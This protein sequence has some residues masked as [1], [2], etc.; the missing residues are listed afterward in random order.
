[1]RAMEATGN[2]EP[3]AALRE[4]VRLLGALLGE[5]IGEQEGETFF[6]LV[7]ATRT[8]S[9]AE[10][11]QGDAG[12]PDAPLQDLG[13]QDAG[14]L[15]Q[16]FSQYFMLVNLAERI[17]RI[18]RLRESGMSGGRPG[19]GTFERVLEKLRDDGLDAESVGRILAALRVMPVFTAHPTEA[20]RPALLR[21]EQRVARALLERLPGGAAPPAVERRR[22]ERIREEVTTAWQTE[23]HR[24]ERPT[25]ADER[26]HIL[27]YLTEVIY[28]VVP[29]FHQEL[30]EAFRDVF[31]AEPEL[32]GGV[33]RFGSWVGGDMDGNPHV[34]ADTLRA[35]L[36]RQ[37]QLV[38]G[39]YLR[40]A[41]DLGRS[42]TQATT[43]VGID[44]AILDRIRA[45]DA[46]LP[47]VERA[48]AA[49]LR[50]RPYGVFFGRVRDRLH[51]RLADAP[52][53]YPG[54]EALL[55]DL[56]LVERSIL[57]NRG[58][59]AG[60]ASVRAFMRRI[61]TFGFHLAAL[62]V[63][64]D[65]SVHRDV[66]AELIGRPDFPAMD[67]AER[68]RLLASGP[69][70]VP[71]P[72]GAEAERA[73]EVMRAL[74][75]ARDRFG[76]DALGVYVISMA[77]GPDDALA[78]LVLA[79]A[80]GLVD[81]QG[82][83]PLDI[84][85]LFETVA[86]LDAARRTL[87][88]LLAEPVYARHLGGRGR[89]QTVM[90]GY[91][92]SSKGSGLLASRWALQRA[93]ESLT[94][95]RGADLTLFH[96]RGGTVSRGGGKPR[97]AVLAEPPGAVRGRLRVTEQGEIINAKYGLEEIAFRT[98]E[99]MAGAVLEATAGD[100]RGTAGAPGSWRAALAGAAS[101]AQTCYRALVVE[102]PAFTSWFRDVTPI[103]VIERMPIGSR[104]A[105]RGAGTAGGVEGLRAIPWVFA[106]TQARMILPGWFGVGSGLEEAERQ[107]GLYLLRE[108]ARDWP[109]FHMLVA[110]V[111]MVLA[112]AD[113]GIAAR[114]AAL[115][116][117]LSERFW[118]VV[119]EEFLRT[120]E[121]LLRILG[122]QELLEGDPVLRS[123]IRLRNP[124][125]DP[126]SLVQ[127][128]LLARWRRG[129]RSDP[130]LEHAL[131]S[132]VQGIARGLQN[133]G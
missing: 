83:V 101:A 66:V 108:M 53:A 34:D 6:G 61:E 38:I 127:V 10:R 44:P 46:L 96:G 133:T 58:A 18:R 85:P 28:E 121:A 81:G 37:R 5:V 19:A 60:A 4:D 99:I 76:P 130:E 64:Q 54:P 49:D 25:V 95:V 72:Y 97:M 84:T 29:R 78:L 89:A 118:P 110:D 9:R 129:G 52:G 69:P 124:Y 68:T 8:A 16:A 105:S 128:E 36:E 104:P 41:E 109:F 106:W 86:D 31:G 51:A 40:E 27:F 90:L 39:R 123:A 98:L 117:T 67:P 73:L 47:E 2:Q 1:M 35:T 50:I 12:P 107:C 63:R 92:D 15:A 132:T 7:E 80:G 59:H 62:D 113:M 55:D 82:A 3:D 21:K 26:E 22:W 70:L 126:M 42:L 75:E 111:E 116:G 20:V 79:R 112:K 114:Y 57:S 71:G 122:H 13:V 17:Q 125:I 103:D 45:H 93:Q 131:F 30:E 115:G 24:S 14:R 120:R 94:E 100:A 33:I 74:G 119:E 48:S 32:P 56:R 23:E 43:K 11:R 88:N 77:Q 91:S 102:D 87:E 65:A